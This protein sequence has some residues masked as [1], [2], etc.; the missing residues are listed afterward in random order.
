MDCRTETPTLFPKVGNYSR[1]AL[2][3]RYP[4]PLFSRENRV[5]AC[6]DWFV[7]Y[8]ALKRCKS[9]YSV[10][11]F[12]AGTEDYFCRLSS[13][14]IRPIKTELRMPDSNRRFFGYEPNEIVRFSNAQ[15]RVGDSNPRMHNARLRLSAHH[16]I[17][18]ITLS[19][20]V[21][22]QTNGL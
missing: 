11:F 17:F 9:M 15:M 4:F 2:L 13:F 14:A 21:N 3:R 10:V 22:S 7:D 6:Q 1:D 5:S 20:S 16:G 19:H 18:A 12:H 8:E